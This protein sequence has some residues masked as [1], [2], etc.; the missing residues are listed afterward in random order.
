MDKVLH[1]SDVV[2]SYISG[3]WGEDN[4][5][6]GTLIEVACVRGADINDVNDSKFDELP[7]RFVTASSLANRC[8]NEGDIVIEKSGGAPTQSTGRVAYISD[9][10]KKAHSNIVCSNFCEA[11]S[12]K[13][14]WDSRYIYYYLQ[15]IYNAGVF[16]NFE[17][18]TSGIHNL[19]IEQAFKSI[20]IQKI[21][22]EEQRKISKILETIEDKIA[23]NRLIISKLETISQL[24]YEYWFVQF[25]FPD[26]NGKPYKSSG[27]EIVYN[28]QLKRDIPH[29]WEV[30]PIG[31]IAQVIN[32]ATPSTKEP[33]NYGGDIVWI[34]PKDLSDQQ[35]KFTIRGERNITQR[36]YDSCS[37]KLLPINTI[38][39]SSRAPIGLFSIA[40]TE[41][42]TN[43]GF[44]SFVTNDDV[45]TTY[46][47]YYLLQHKESIEQIGARTTFREVSRDDMLE[48]RVLIP[49]SDLLKIYAQKNKTIEDEQFTLQKEIDSLTHQRDEL[50]PLL[51]NGQVTIK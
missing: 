7:I 42:C 41:L 44:K 16:F 21:D 32:G 12:V 43:Q 50:L 6:N 46:L 14:E 45:Y 35:T 10:C 24:L 9:K 28:S 8:L 15:F 5:K 18:K 2:K 29:G 26:A 19:D 47:Y 34:T 38:L 48:F 23:T 3:D 30:K 25:D 17:G 39:M 27:G 1:I 4:N 11:F 13:P 22:I 51:M 49:N 36:G 37:T 31:E 33:Q 40:K 20:P